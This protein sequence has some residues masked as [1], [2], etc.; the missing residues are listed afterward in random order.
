M[1]FP[2]HTQKSLDQLTWN[3][4]QKIHASLGLKAA[5]GA[6]TRRDYQRRIVAA[7]PQPVVEAEQ[8]ATAMTCAT[9][10]F[11]ILLEDNRYEC[12]A[13]VTTSVTRG[14]WEAKD[15][16]YCVVAAQVQAETT[17]PAAEVE[18]PAASASPHTAETLP[19][20]NRNKIR[21]QGHVYTLIA[22]PVGHIE[23]STLII[24][25]GSVTGVVVSVGKAYF[26]LYS[27][28]KN[29]D[30]VYEDLVSR[31]S[32]RKNLYELLEKGCQFYRL[33]Q[34][35]GMPAYY[36]SQALLELFA[37]PI[38]QP[39]ETPASEITGTTT[40]DAPPNR[41]DNGRGRVTALT[42]L[43]AA[44]IVLPHA[45]ADDNFMTAFTKESEGDRKFNDAE[46]EQAA[47]PLT[48]ATCPLARLIE[49]DRYCC[50]RTDRVTRS[51]WEA[52]DNCYDAVAAQVETE[53]EVA[54]PATGV[55]TPIAPKTIQFQQVSLAEKLTGLTR[56][57]FRYRHDIMG[58]GHCFTSSMF[59]LC[60]CNKCNQKR[61]LSEREQPR[62][63][64]QIMLGRLSKN[65]TPTTRSIQ[66]LQTQMDVKQ[67]NLT[68]FKI[69]PFHQ[70]ILPTE[71]EGVP[72]EIEEPEGTIHWHSLTAGT[73]VGKKGVRSFYLRQRNCLI[74][75]Y[76]IMVVIT[77]DFTA[78][79]FK[80][81]NVHHQRIR[82]AIEAGRT[83][84]PKAF[85]NSGEFLTN[86]EDY[87]GLG[88][89][90][91]GQDGRWWA[92]AEGGVTGQPFP[93]KKLATQYLDRVAASKRKQ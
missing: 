70:S 64:H 46:P 50:G 85:K 12:G 57:P 3:E 53:A 92:W 83:F 56:H 41:G 63:S 69:E 80:R 73:I 18:A 28:A 9:C 51:H 37:L 58:G 19:K 87:R 62:G 75:D 4:V 88:R 39:K 77:N 17:E 6:R 90:M 55:E 20:M 48:C 33:D 82:T 74:S 38:T 49:D 35:Q 67:D 71:P 91:Q 15:E 8:T 60:E 59:G 24:L 27:S 84:D 93:C 89:I 76:E 30:I 21:F 22:A 11:V 34:F 25:A 31:I 13:K 86:T 14:H 78:S 52:T 43:Q 16:C 5:A 72:E 36:G 32:T 23:R 65:E 66:Q 40:D 7:M 29:W 26:P 81:P 79:E 1:T 54:E 42:A 10:P 2:V 61:E 44:T 45:K 68:L 47:T